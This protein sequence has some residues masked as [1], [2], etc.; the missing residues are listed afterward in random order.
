LIYKNKKIMIRILFTLVS[1]F[2]LS[3]V[4]GQTIDF[5]E[6][7]ISLD[8]FLNGSDANGQFQSQN[9]SLPNNFDPEF[10]SWLGWS[11]SS[12]RDSMTPGFGNQYAAIPA[13]GFEGS[14]NYA[15]SFQFGEN[16]LQFENGNSGIEGLYVTNNTYAYLSMRDG[17]AFAK[18]FGGE[19]GDDPDFFL[20]T[21][22]GYTDG[23]QVADTVQ[24]YLA[25]YRFEDNSE[26]YLISEWTYVDLSSLGGV[27][28]LGFS[29]S[30]S[31]NGQFG[32]NTPA[33]FCIDQIT[34]MENTRTTV[35]DVFVKNAFQVYPNPVFE[36]LS[37]SH[38]ISGEVYVQI[39]NMLG[40]LVYE[41]Q[42]FKTKNINVSTLES[43][44]YIL[45]LF[46]EQLRSS[47]LFVKQ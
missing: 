42:D 19:I 1:I 9:L 39:Y 28:S 2:S 24:F 3:I 36:N 38:Y 4:Q 37:L 21:V 34:L 35:D 26:D 8:T 43:G 5:E 46:G 47:R 12:V 23:E 40:K 11:I 6:F 17:D 20:L 16:G 33:Y 7:E 44:S 22:L 41:S 25:D 30:S 31:D 14:R 13:S 29:L 18:K 45:Q 15:V 27:D 10:Q 32:M